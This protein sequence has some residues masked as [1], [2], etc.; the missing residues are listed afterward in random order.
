MYGNT[1]ELIELGCSSSSVL[2]LPRF[3]GTIIFIFNF[4]FSNFEL[5]MKIF[6]FVTTLPIS[7]MDQYKKITLKRKDNKCGRVEV[8]VL[9]TNRD[10]S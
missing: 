3:Y 5:L 1:I 8:S 10:I 9:T 7:S 2:I 4:Y 6:I